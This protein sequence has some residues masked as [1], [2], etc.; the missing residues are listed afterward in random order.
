MTRTSSSHRYVSHDVLSFTFS[1]S[2]LPFLLTQHNL[3]PVHLYNWSR[4]N[5]CDRKLHQR[6]LTGFIFFSFSPSPFFVCLFISRHR[7]VTGQLFFL[8]IASNFNVHCSCTS[9]VMLYCLCVVKVQCTHFHLMFSL[10]AARSQYNPLF[11][12]KK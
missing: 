3:H 8:S 9:C 1:V 4:K 6:Q 7:R 2:L 10:Q 12:V 5:V 11:T